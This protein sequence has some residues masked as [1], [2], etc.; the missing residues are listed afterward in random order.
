VRVKTPAV[1]S[2]SKQINE[3][4]FPNFIG[5]RKASRMQYVPIKA[6]QLSGLD[7]AQVGAAAA[8]VEWTDLQK[9][10]ARVNKCEFIPGATINE[11]AN[12]LAD[13]LIA[14]KVI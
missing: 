11:K 2:V 8:L 9:P 13:K 6:A 10:A 3:P 1:I 7:P 12:A 14:E 5:I 4:R